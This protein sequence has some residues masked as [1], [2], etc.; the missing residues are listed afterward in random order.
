M[1]R[2]THSLDQHI[3]ARRRA[4]AEDE[5]Y[6][7][8]SLSEKGTDGDRASGGPMWDCASYVCIN[9]LAV[10]V[11]FVLFVFFTAHGLFN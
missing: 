9:E 8:R 10:S 11:C 2:R 6:T 5:I 3:E 1:T 4:E 7:D